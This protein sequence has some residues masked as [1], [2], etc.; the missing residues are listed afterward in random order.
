MF[1]LKE[2]RVGGYSFGQKTFYSDHHFGTDYSAKYVTLYMPFT[3]TITTMTGT[4]GG[5]TIW[6]MPDGKD[7][8][9]RFKVLG[10]VKLPCSSLNLY[11]FI[12]T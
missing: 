6:V 5:N 12:C 10:T 3:G 8:V 1:P 7:I 9:I 2:R 11:E 4:Q